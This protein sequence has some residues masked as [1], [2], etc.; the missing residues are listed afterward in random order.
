M[1]PAGSRV[2]LSTSH[3]TSLF[4]SKRKGSLNIQT[5]ISSMSLLCPLDWPVLE[6]SKFHSGRSVKEQQQQKLNKNI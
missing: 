4:G 1:L 2:C 6:P 5:G 3:S